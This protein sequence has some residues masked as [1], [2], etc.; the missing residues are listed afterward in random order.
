MRH[1][2]TV[3]GAHFSSE[4]E[5]AAFVE[6]LYDEDGDALLSD[7]E[8]SIGSDGID[9]DFMEIHHLNDEEEQLAFIQYLKSEYVP[10][11]SFVNGLPATINESIKPYNSI[12]LVSGSDS[13]YGSINEELFQFDKADVE[14]DSPVVLLT[15][16][17]YEGR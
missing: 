12:I 5:L 11:D 2:V 16:V 10:D 15:S 8:D 13:P 6:T 4:D 9:E 17:E 1:I 3:W 14:S 7:F